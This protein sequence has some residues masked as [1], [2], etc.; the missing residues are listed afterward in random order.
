MN[1]HRD[2][3]KKSKKYPGIYVPGSLEED[4]ENENDWFTYLNQ[5]FTDHAGKDSPFPGSH[6]EYAREDEKHYGK[7]PKGWKRSDD[8]I[9][10]EVCEALY[11]SSAVDASHIEVNVVNGKV[12]L[13]GSVSTRQEK[14]E[15]E[16]LV[17][18][19]MGV[20]DVHNKLQIY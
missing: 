12:A 16:R 8:R 9:H 20:W 1:E 17:E 11:H 10:E 18:N 19:L 14:K 6:W 7:G 15:A 5:N 2:K 4:N 13:S 3:E